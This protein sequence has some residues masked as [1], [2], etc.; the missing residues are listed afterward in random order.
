[1]KVSLVVQLVKDQ[2]AMQETPVRFLGWE[3]PLDKGWA[4]HSSILDL[5]VWLS[6]LRIHLQ[7]GRLG[8]N[9]W[10]G[11]IPWRKERLLTPVF[12]PGEFHGLYSP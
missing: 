2:P 1:M 12:W 5:P 4:T 6:W 3:D 10:A 9:P 7:F 8:F 11:K